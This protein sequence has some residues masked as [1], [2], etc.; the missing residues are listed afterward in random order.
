GQ[1]TVSSGQTLTV[2]GGL[3]FDTPRHIFAGSGLVRFT[4][5]KT[6]STFYVEWWGA[7]AADA[8]DDTADIQEALDAI[9]A[10]GIDATIQFLRGTYTIAGAL[11]DTGASNSQLVLPKNDSS[12]LTTLRLKG[13]APASTFAVPTDG[14]VL[15]ST[16]ASGNGSVIGVRTAHVFASV[17][18]LTWLSLHVEDVVVRTVDN[19]TISGLD[20]TYIPN[21]HLER[22]QVFA[23]TDSTITEPTTAT[24]YAI[25]LPLN[26]PDV[27][28]LVNVQATGFYTGLLAGELIN[29]DDLVINFTKVAIEVVAATHPLRFGRVVI[30]ESVTALKCSGEARIDIEQFDVEHDNVNP[31]NWWTFST[32]VVDSGDLCQGRINFN[33][34]LKN[35]GP[36]NSFA[37][38]GGRN[39][40]IRQT[41]RPYQWRYNFAEPFT[42]A[43][44]KDM[45]V[46]EL[47]SNQAVAADE[48]FAA[49]LA[50]TNQSGLNNAIFSLFA[51]NYALA[52][53]DKRVGIME[54]LTGGAADS[55]RFDFATMNAGTRATRFSILPG[56][57][58]KLAAVGALPGAYEPDAIH[59]YAEG[60][61]AELK[62]RD[63][64]GTVTTLSP[65]SSDGPEWLYDAEDSAPPH[66]TAE[67]NVYAG[68]VRFVNHTRLARLQQRQ[69]DGESMPAD[70][71]RR[72][73]ISEE[74]FEQYNARKGFKAGDRGFLVIEDWDTNQEAYRLRREAK[75]AEWAAQRAEVE[76]RRAEWRERKE[77]A[78]R[79]GEQFAEAEPQMEPEPEAY[80]PQPKPAWLKRA[81]GPKEKP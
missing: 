34:T 10:S 49:L 9:D 48:K 46:L 68:T 28:R 7:N 2:L 14:T 47:N 61:S 74:T 32:D 31:S 4:G 44:A 15:K 52:A 40:W 66:V 51:S 54:I 20:L 42:N 8:A 25:K 80:T 19:P 12:S 39:L 36:N 69:F 64:G 33:L 11:Q 65:H 76:R 45:S 27:R 18:G 23:G 3:T 55:G 50:G 22:V 56:G 13:A 5:N 29:A 72:K 63:E 62:A 58:L 67:V 37:L 1:L 70:P 60:A 79:R 24:S 26:V 21:L 59:L 81:K 57:A 78:G 38:T 71:L 73:V 6:L 77:R 30:T 41:R 53:A 43:Y 35:S 75:R 17:T 16:L